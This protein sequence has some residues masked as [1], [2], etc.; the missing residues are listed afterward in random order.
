MTRKRSEAFIPADPATQQPL[1]QRLIAI[2]DQLSS[3]FIARD[4][5]IRVMILAH[6]VG[7][8]YLL[9]GSPGTAKSAVS[10]AFVKH[11]TGASHF[12]V[13]FGAFTTP[14]KIFGPLDVE[15]FTTRK[16]FKY[17]TDG[18]L[19][20]VDLA[21][22]EEYLKGPDGCVNE[23]LGILNEREFMGEQVPL[24][25]CGM[26]TN[27][28]ELERRS[29]K[30]DAL[31]D[32]TLLRVAVEDITDPKQVA[33]M[34]DRSE[35]VRSYTPE[36]FVDLAELKAAREELR[37]IPIS[38]DVRLVLAQ[39][40]DRLAFKQTSG[41]ERVPNI[42]IS[43]R[44]LAALQDVLRAQA[45]LDGADHVGVEHFEPLR[46]GLWNDR[47]DG[48]QVKA[49][50][51]AVDHDTVKNMMRLVGEGREAIKS[52][53]QKRSGMTQDIMNETVTRVAVAA[54]EEFDKPIFTARG[55]EQVAKEMRAFKAEFNALPKTA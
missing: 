36:A 29:D 3:T 24:W 28:P 40:R 5:A 45:W 30:I 48:E 42:A 23:M 10:T 51:D 11:V 1:R 38:V 41:G 12:K 22:C 14:E 44:R 4:E 8:H 18:M 34:L 54:R 31:Y 52:F 6:L 16:R 35:K 32:R 50:L 33:E 26:N 37:Q 21:T 20:S 13:L 53:V 43:S 19:P 15:E 27:W 17:A 2:R 25:T 39:V 55:K 47:R 49:V 46:F 9:V 7:Q